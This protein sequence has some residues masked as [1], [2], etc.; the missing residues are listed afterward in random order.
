MKK[1]HFFQH[2]LKFLGHIVSDN[3]VEVDPDKTQA[4]SEYPVP[5]D[6]LSLQ[7]FLGLV[8][9][10]HEFIP[11]F[12]D[13]AVSLNH[14]KRKG[15]RWNWTQEC[16]DSFEQLKR[17][18][19]N[20]PVLSQPN[21]SL[22]FQVHTNASDVRL[23]AV[24]TQCTEEGEKVIAYAS[25]ML[26]GVATNYSTSE[27]ECLAVVWAVDKWR[28]YLEGVEF[29]VYTDHA[30]LTWAFNCPKTSSRLTRWILRPQAFSFK[31]FYRRGCLNQVPDALSRIYPARS[32]GVLPCMVIT[33]S[34]LTT[35]LPH[36]LSEIAKAQASDPDIPSLKKRNQDLPQK[37]GRIQME[38]HQGILYRRVPLKQD[39]HK[40]QM[41]VPQV[42][43]D[44]P[45]GGHLGRLKTLMRVL[46]VAWWSTVRKDVCEHVK[47]CNVCQR[48]KGECSK[49]SGL[50]QST[51]VTE[52][53]HTLGID[54]MGPLPLSK[55]R[56]TIL[57]VIVDYY[58]KWVELFPLKDSTTPKI[59]KMLKEEI[60]TR[61][62]VPRYLVSD[63]GPQFTSYLL[64]E[65]CK[66]WG[67][68]QKLT[69]S[70]HPQT[71]LT[72]RVNKTLKTMIASFVGD[73]HSN[74]DQWLPELR[75]AINSAHQES[76]GVTPAQLMLGRSLKGP[77]E[78]LLYKSPS[79]N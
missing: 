33:R 77:L 49:P 1:C 42:F 6:I 62:G 19:T 23:R 71:N 76:T 65:L 68:G 50:M 25:R 47:T 46:E 61:L 44:N 64:V 24:L 75:F 72:E 58:T 37:P 67:V 38:E 45:L 52:P 79:L 48:Y 15:V 17:A 13:V 11:H 31:V 63:K 32:E 57:L 56:N 2:Q 51:E 7:R 41:V 3:G 20:P 21:L 69:T 73:K 78:R 39:G 29:E 8:G 27:K 54:L 70:Y 4:I 10:Y 36:N 55:K 9:W 53:S 66:D 35:D 22:P 26:K 60:S 34:K 40:F 14:M 30:A 43:H 12:A 28:H 5:G 59:V 74:W 18:V 16:Q